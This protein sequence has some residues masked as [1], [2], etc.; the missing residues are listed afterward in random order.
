MADSWVPVIWLVLPVCALLLASGWL[1]VTAANL[2]ARAAY[3]SF[4]ATAALGLAAALIGGGSATVAPLHIAIAL[5]ALAALISVSL[6]LRDGPSRVVT[7]TLLPAEGHRTPAMLR[8]VLL[9]EHSKQAGAAE[10]RRYLELAT[11]A[12]QVTV[13]MQNADL[14]YV[15]IVNP[16]LGFDEASVIGRSDYDVLPEEAQPLV[17]GHKRRAL[18]TGSSQTFELSVPEKG[19]TVWFRVN[20][21]PVGDVSGQPEGVVC[22]AIDITRA[23]RLDMMRTDL[24][25]RLAETLQRFNL[26]LRSERII[27]FSQDL[28]MRYTWANSEETQIGSIIGRT[29][30]DVIPDADRPAVLALK[31]KAI[32]TREPQSGQIGIGAEPQRRW[33]DL[34]VEPNIRPDG[35]VHGITCA[36]I[37]ITEQKRSEAQMRLVMRELTHRTKNLLAVVIAIARQTSAQAKDVDVFVPALI[38][39]LRALSAAQDLIVADDWAGVSLRSLIQLLLAQHPARSAARVDVV[40]PEVILSPEAAQNLGLA[41]HEL[42]S[43]AVQFGALSN[44]DGALSVTWSVEHRGG[45]ETLSVV[46]QEAGGPHV[47]QPT[48]RGFGMTVIERNLTRALSAKV[49]L[50]FSPG[51]LCARLQVPLA[52]ITPLSAAVEERL[53]RVG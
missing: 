41:I 23:K 1:T 45:S 18:E 52:G 39:R 50:D 42:I 53:D 46:W 14:E 19:E 48:K 27:V 44:D 6:A 21:V 36:S 3:L 30:T 15:W 16:R 8:R 43:N 28:E 51:G 31:E 38:G 34:H 40:G 49:G 22:T 11:E 5:M 26:A 32:E 25:R 9:R 20:V 13:F 4:T 47:G 29:D 24:S 17:I 33:F 7:A 2:P 37:D 35:S 12:A 10:M